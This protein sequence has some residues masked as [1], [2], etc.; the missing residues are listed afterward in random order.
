MIEKD[1]KGAFSRRYL[2]KKRKQTLGKYARQAVSFLLTT[3][4]MFGLWIV[5]SGKFEPLL[6]VLGV[7]ASLIVALFSHTLLFA[8]P[9]LSGYFNSTVRFLAYIP[10]LIY[11]VLLANIHVLRLVFHPKMMEKIDPHIVVFQTRLRKDFSIVT[12]ANSITLTPGT[13]TVTADQD[14]E[15]RVHA[16]DLPSA[17][18]LPGQMEKRVAKV[19]GEDIGDER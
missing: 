2:N 7:I 10:W 14:G 9:S 13:I 16:I 11:Q 15:F 3:V 19:F 8:S 17:E 12:M 5:L 4:L 18:G 6:L 1:H